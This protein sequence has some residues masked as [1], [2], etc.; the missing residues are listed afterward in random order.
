MDSE[1]PTMIQPKGTRRPRDARARSLWRTGIATAVTAGLVGGF[2]PLSSA[3]AAPSPQPSSGRDY[4][5]IPAA[6][7]VRPL[8]EIPSGPTTPG[9]PGLPE[10]VPGLGVPLG[11]VGAGSFMVNQSGTFGPWFF[12]GSQDDSWETRA[13]TQAAFHVRE[14]VG[15]NP[16]TVKTLAT[17]GPQ[18]TS[19]ARSWESPLPA[20]NVLQPGE[21][22]YAALYPFGYTS[23]TPFKTDVSMRFF[24]PIVAGE[25]R[26]TSLPVAYFDVR[27][28]NHTGKTSNVSVMFTMPNVPGHE[29][30]QPATVRTGLASS[31]TTDKKSG[32][33]AV[34]LSSDDPSNTA[35]AT[36]SEWTIAAQPQNGQRVSYTTSWNANGD[37]SDV[38]APFTSTGSLA[39]TPIDG[40]HSAGA[41]SVSVKLKP[42][43]VSTVPFAL[44]WDF[45]QVSFA[46]NNSVWMRRYTDFYGAKEDKQNNYVQGSYPFHQS[47]AIAR[48]ALADHDQSLKA[49][50]R[51]WNPIANESAYPV[52]LRTGALN[53][54][55]QVPFKTAL[56]EGGLVSNTV[57]PTGG[58]RQGTSVPGTHL[59]LGVDSNAGGGAN[60][61]MG[62]E[63]GTYSYLA[64]RQVFP[65]IERD[66]LQAKIDAVL[67][68]PYGDP[69]DP[70]LTSSTDPAAY[71]ATGDPFITWTQGSQPSPGNV[72]FI[73]RPSENLFRLYDYAQSSHDQGFLK[74]A[75][76]AMQK[77][78]S[79]IQAT[80][81]AGSTLPQAPNMNAPSPDLKSP[82][83]YANVFDVI[84]VNKVDAYDSQLYL[85]A[86]ESI[87][88][89]GKK[90]GVSRE[91]LTKWSGQLKAAKA[92]YEATF[93]NPDHQYYRYTPGPSA[94]N[95]SVLLA[96]LFAQHLAERAGLPDLVDPVHYR[97]QLITQTGLFASQADA[98]GNK[99]GSPNMALPPGSTGFPYTGFAGTTYEDGV[100][101]TVNYFMGATYVDAAKRFGSA[102]F[103]Q[104]G[105]DLGSA[106]ATQIWNVDSNGYQFNAPL[107][108]N[109][110][111]SGRWIYPAFESNLASWELIN[112]IKPVNIP[113]S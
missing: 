42:G 90:L 83:P 79:Y 5:A 71:T 76:P 93:W 106:V 41:I 48:D 65:T 82:L 84:P 74:R 31:F 46:D 18:G 62:T 7:T 9:F 87:S 105:I 15:D 86:L 13:L 35:D 10:S 37:G 11:G 8:G 21:G 112:A 73:D 43:E 108:W 33:Q 102:Q 103:R 17:D 50:E 22:S 27:L 77:L 45:P 6:A 16:A 97:Q 60:G 12:G 96:T 66:R 32:V 56:W 95:D 80:I 3:L 49:V 28:A 4:F 110:A 111:D 38:Y 51:W 30:R 39:D 61:G 107:Q 36:K 109:K 91:T 55:A 81:P 20:W 54:L 92:E 89:A 14:Q 64:Y 44:S 58:K 53:Q 52:V 94:D 98:Q 23:Y 25:D 1:G 19:A 75:Y 57:T 69:W 68:D 29:G 67:A 24:S 59:Y 2:L 78:L 104:T 88:A 100:W 26:R 72:W 99:I 47:F 34:T 63:V 40:S 113:G 70:G 101:P 85:L